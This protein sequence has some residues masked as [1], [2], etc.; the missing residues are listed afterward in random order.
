MVAFTL[1]R[2]ADVPLTGKHN[3]GLVGNKWHVWKLEIS[4]KV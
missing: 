1:Q 2:P 3:D 4:K